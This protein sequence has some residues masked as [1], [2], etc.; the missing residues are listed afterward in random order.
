MLLLKPLFV[1]ATLR[2]STSLRFVL[3]QSCVV[4]MTMDRVKVIPQIFHLKEI[5]TRSEIAPKYFN[6][7]GKILLSILNNVNN[8]NLIITIITYCLYNYS[9]EGWTELRKNNHHLRNVIE[10]KMYDR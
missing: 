3:A 7:N 10:P 6:E 4:C 5:S 8:N 2:A 1:T 9:V